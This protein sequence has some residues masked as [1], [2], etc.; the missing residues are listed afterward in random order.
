MIGSSFDSLWK[1][2]ECLEDVLMNKIAIPQVIGIM[3]AVS[4][5]PKSAHMTR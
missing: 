3:S 5:C 4:S 2:F 1:P